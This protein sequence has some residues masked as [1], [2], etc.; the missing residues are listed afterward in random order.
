MIGYMQS[1]DCPLCSAAAGALHEAAGV[2]YFE[3]T[4]CDF[5]FADRSVLKRIDAGEPI[6][7]YNDDYW[8]MELPDARDRAFG[9]SLIRVAEALLYARHDVVRFLDVG[10]GPGYLLDALAIYLPR[11][12]VFYGIETFPPP[13]EYRSRHPQYYV[14]GLDSLY[15]RIFNAGTCI[16]VIEHL[17]PSMLSKL[18]YDLARISG[19]DSLYL[20]NTGLT[21][22][23]KKENIGYLNP[24][25]KGHI[26]SWSVTAAAKVLGQHGFTVLPI[27]GKTWAFVAEY[28]SSG[29]EGDIRNRIWSVLPHNKGIL[30]DVEMG[31]VL[32]IAGLDTARAY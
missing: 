3:C 22:Y 11:S 21:S 24:I 29:S 8:R 1:Q 28:R 17:T 13:A 23:V 4:A 5:I 18:G 2:P 19:T 15:G 26:C 6:R 20:F 10:T 9:T 16:E 27:P 25:D 7:R 30:H 32:Y 12:R 14:G 31:S